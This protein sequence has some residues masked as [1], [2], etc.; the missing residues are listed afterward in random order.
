MTAEEVCSENLVEDVDNV[1][2]RQL[3]LEQWTD[4]IVAQQ[5]TPSY[6][7]IK[8]DSER[9]CSAENSENW[10]KLILN[11]K[12]ALSLDDQHFCSAPGTIRRICSAN[13]N[14]CA[15]CCEEVG[16][17]SGSVG[18]GMCRPQTGSTV[19]YTAVVPGGDGEARAL[20]LLWT[21]TIDCCE[22]RLL[23]SYITKSHSL[24]GA[25]LN[26]EGLRAK[27]I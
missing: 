17:V 13:N 22:W 16:G 24:F 2:N 18:L 15:L 27:H 23:F 12:K 5:Q 8:N 1:N 14:W 25:I 26:W 19:A 21:T 9:G 7:R 4:P 20:H 3:Q 10:Q 11:N 6:C